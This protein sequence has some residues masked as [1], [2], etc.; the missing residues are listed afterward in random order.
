VT[1]IRNG[2]LAKIFTGV[3]AKRLTLVETITRKSNQHE[4]QGVKPLRTLFGEQDRKNIPTTFIWMNRE[5]EAMS[6]RGFVSWSNVRKGKPRSAEYHLYYSNNSITEAMNVRD[7][8]FIA[9]KPDNEALVIVVPAG[10]GMLHQL[11]WLFGIDV[12]Q[13]L[14][15]SEA[16]DKSAATFVDFKTERPAEHR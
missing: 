10:S 1:A 3:V 12:Q 14:Q 13:Q 6:D 2:F 8:A 16:D 15:I 7:F 4:F 9:L 11:Y 5:Q